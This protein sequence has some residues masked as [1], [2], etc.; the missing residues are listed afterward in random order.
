L[1]TKQDESLIIRRIVL[2]ENI[3]FLK[4]FYSSLPQPIP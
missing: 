3:V 2:E 1:D 4:G